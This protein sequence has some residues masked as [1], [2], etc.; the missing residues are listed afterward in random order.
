MAGEN[1]PWF[2]SAQPVQVRLVPSVAATLGI[3][4]ADVPVEAVQLQGGMLLITVRIDATHITRYLLPANALQYARQSIN[5]G[6]APTPP[7]S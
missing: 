6:G 2:D 4:D 7:Q 1:V 5:T 3:P